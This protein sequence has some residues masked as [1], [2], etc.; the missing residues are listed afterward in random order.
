[1]QRL[2]RATGHR[3]AVLV[4]TAV[5]AGGLGAVLLLPGMAMASTLP[6]PASTGSHSPQQG[7][8]SA[9]RFEASNPPLT[10]TAGSDYQYT[11]T[12]SGHPSY[13]LSG[14]PGWLSI[15]AA[16][17]QVSGNVPGGTTSF[18]YSVIASDAGG[19]ATSGQYSVRVASGQQQSGSGNGHRPGGYQN[20][21]YLTTQLNCPSS[22]KAGQTASCTLTVTDNGSSS[23]RDVTAS[24]DLPSALQAKYCGQAADWRWGW[25]GADCSI[26][27]NDATAQLGTVQAG[28]SKT[29][30]VYFRASDSWSWRSSDKVKVTGSAQSGSGY[31]GLGA[32]QEAQSTAYVTVYNRRFG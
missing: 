31:A 16:T 25:N 2:I 19:T 24:I 29:V 3:K 17:G 9:P 23:A 8:S 32:G 11:F 22:V 12:A 13:S 15:N 30:S 18:N 5:M 14:A 6:A 7:G 27:G 20:R 10:A 1:M 4:T 21:S 26:S 28:Q